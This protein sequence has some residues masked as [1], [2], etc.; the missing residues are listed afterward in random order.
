VPPD[1][2]SKD[3]GPPGGHPPGDPGEAPPL[4]D[5][6]D[7]DD[8]GACAPAPGPGDPWDDPDGDYDGSVLPAWLPLP[9]TLAEIPP[10]LGG[11]PRRHPDPAWPTPPAP[12]SPGDPDG[13]TRRPAAGLLDLTISRAALTG[14]PAAL[15]RLGPVSTAQALPLAV[16]AISNPAAQWRVILTNPA[17][18]A[19]AIERVRRGRLC[20]N[21]GR[22]PGV[23]GRV[24]VTIPAATLITAAATSGT[25]WTGTG[26]G[27][28]AA[29]LRAARRAAARAADTAAA[30]ADAGGC[31]HTAATTAYRPATRTREHVTARDKT[32]R[33]P[34]CA[35][36]AWRAD[37][38]HTRP[39]HQGGPT[40]SCNLGGV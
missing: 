38:D 26:R 21:P 1:G 32:C 5:A 10:F 6:P 17:G 9:D 15:G 22:P 34:C 20:D 40:C 23:T 24:T 35:Q 27:I 13:T 33:Q 11:Q 31:A 14:A 7:H 39:W 19:I 30:D 12:A 25:G 3:G 8:G 4:T 2:G 18:H 28:R 36:P 37:L 29:V 16:L